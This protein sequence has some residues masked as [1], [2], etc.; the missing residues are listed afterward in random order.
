MGEASLLVLHHGLA[1]VTDGLAEVLAARGVPVPVAG[2]GDRDDE[3]AA[4][5][6]RLP[7]GTI[8]T[9]DVTP[10]PAHVTSGGV[11][12]RLGELVGDERRVD[13]GP[14]HAHPA[15]IGLL[16]DLLDDA[17]D[18]VP[19]DGTAHVLFTAPSLPAAIVQHGDRYP[20]M[21]RETAAAVSERLGLTRRTIAWHGA[22][23]GDETWLRPDIGH[24]LET[25]ATAHGVD[26]VVCCPVGRVA[27][28][29]A[30]VEDLDRE[31][32]ARADTLGIRFVRV[33]TAAASGRLLEVLADVV[34]ASLR[35]VA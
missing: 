7:A 24:V 21:L 33:P 17:R 30:L 25:L 28:V 4:A 8:M 9:L 20:M 12:R 11:V 3:L 13:L 22:P 19:A 2:A 32:A 16:A 10:M 14:W 23:A 26:T 6:D 31:A 27:D 18:T 34:T 5:V 35:R 15:W 1:G 29:P